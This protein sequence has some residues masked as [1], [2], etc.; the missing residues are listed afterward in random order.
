MALPSSAA[1]RGAAAS[2]GPGFKS[3]DVITFGLNGNARYLSPVGLDFESAPDFSWT[4]ERFCGID[5]P[6]EAPGRDLT[7]SLLVMPWVLGT[8]VPAQEAAVYVN[9]LLVT[10]IHVFNEFDA[11]FSVEADALQSGL[12]KLRLIIPTAVRPRSLGA[13]ADERL[14]GFQLKRL[15]LS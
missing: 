14:L 5:I 1:R 15:T 4:T 10:Y 11:A 13:G 3:G 9:G 12:A 8:R 2:R 6:L 7:L